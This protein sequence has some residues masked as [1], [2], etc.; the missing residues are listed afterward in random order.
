[1]SIVY[2]SGGV[3]Y[4]SD[5]GE[6][7]RIT[8]NL[9][10]YLPITVKSIK[11]DNISKK[12]LDSLVSL[13][14][15]LGLLMR[16]NPILLGLLDAGNDKTTRG[17]IVADF[18][19][20][21]PYLS[22][23]DKNKLA[24]LVEYVNFN[25]VL[26][27]SGNLTKDFSAELDKLK[28]VLG[29]DIYDRLLDNNLITTDV[30]G[31]IT[32]V[33]G[34][35]DVN[36]LKSEGVDPNLV[37]GL[38]ASVL[39]RNDISAITKI[40]Y[41]SYGLNPVTGKPAPELAVQP[42]TLGAPIAVPP[43]VN[44]VSPEQLYTEPNKSDSNEFLTEKVNKLASIMADIDKK[45]ISATDDEKLKL[46]EEYERANNI[47][48]LAQIELDDR[49][50]N[51]PFSDVV[52]IGQPLINS[53]TL[54]KSEIELIADRARDEPQSSNDVLPLSTGQLRLLDDIVDDDVMGQQTLS[55]GVA[56]PLGGAGRQIDVRNPEGKPFKLSDSGSGTRPM[57]P[58]R[59]N[60]LSDEDRSPSKS[61][62]SRSVDVSMVPTLDYPFP[63]MAD[64]GAIAS[65]APGLDK[66][67]ASPPLVLIPPRNKPKIVVIPKTP[68]SASAAPP[69]TEQPLPSS[70]PETSERENQPALSKSAKKRIRLRRRGSNIPS[71]G[72]G[73]GITLE[74][75]GYRYRTETDEK[76]FKHLMDSMET[77][78]GKTILEDI[79]Q[80][81]EFP[82]NVMGHTIYR[83]L[84][85]K[86]VH[87]D[88]REDAMKENPVKL[89]NDFK[90]LRN[91]IMDRKKI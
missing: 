51:L 11:T 35:T 66:V 85:P 50:S 1:M 7:V 12:L 24:S 21:N 39:P 48:T 57:S 67:D 2:S 25:Q 36:R 40:V 13:D 71:E 4:I 42:E 10:S 52:P 65:T 61:K 47:G 77:E 80:L 23:N 54:Q 45:L 30:K 28:E 55:V 29:P 27:R 63:D 90:M 16:Q 79:Y 58:R 53:S 86:T 5:Y 83:Q 44:L 68:L 64:D 20:S 18:I 31:L 69:P 46:N 76:E 91:Y 43:V 56:G 26:G 49:K 82:K 70:T 41:E 72:S 15:K 38:L 59:P 6:P 89:A 88:L 37:A 33:L 84:T 19:K 73:S 81:D 78:T 60:I 34:T 87:K 32:N 9:N 17:Q 3:S 14:P 75:R 62:T 74:R 8:R 22:S